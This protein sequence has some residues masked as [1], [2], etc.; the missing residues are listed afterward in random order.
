MTEDKKEELLESMYVALRAFSEIAVATSV[1]HKELTE[2]LKRAMVDVATQDYGI[3]GRPTNVSRV[4]AMTGLTRK[5][6]RKIRDDIEAGK[7]LLSG[8]VSPA[9]RTLERWGSDTQYLDSKGN[10]AVL[11]YD[12]KG[13]TFASLVRRHAGDVPPG[14]IRTELKRMGCVREL[15]NGDI[16]Y[17]GCEVLSEAEIGNISSGLRSIAAPAMASVARDLDKEDRRTSELKKRDLSVSLNRS[18]AVRLRRVWENVAEEMMQKIEKMVAAYEL[19]YQGAPDSGGEL[20]VSIGS[21][22][23]AEQSRE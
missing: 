3:R 15:E 12:G 17:L 14:A 23:F 22:I 8:Q 7:R 18:D 19:L 2:I 11:P 6:V 10:P 4:S 21:Y 20:K 1:S 16:R 9:L 13:A 5:S